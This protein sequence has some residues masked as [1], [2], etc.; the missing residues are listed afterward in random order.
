M[1]HIIIIAYFFIFIALITT[2]KNN[3]KRIETGN[4]T[5][6]ELNEKELGVKKKSVYDNLFSD[7]L[8]NATDYAGKYNIRESYPTNYLDT[9]TI[10]VEN[11]LFHIIYR[12][13]YFNNDTE[14]F[15]PFQVSIIEKNNIVILGD[16]IGEN[17]KIFLNK[18]E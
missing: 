16:F 7:I 2:C 10:I 9:E 3:E 11:N 8:P 1:R 18:F 17:V 4:I 15:V 6:I 14:K 5:V 13:D 12:P